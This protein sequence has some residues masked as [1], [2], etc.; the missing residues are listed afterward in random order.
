MLSFLGKAMGKC[1]ACGGRLITDWE[2]GEV[3]CVQCGLVV[4]EAAVD[5]GPEWRA[6]E[7]MERARAAPLKLRLR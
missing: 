3:V 2:R 4:A 5:T 6:F 7:K 1:P